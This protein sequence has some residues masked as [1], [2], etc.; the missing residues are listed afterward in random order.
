MGMRVALILHVFHQPLR[1]D[2]GAENVALRVGGNAFG[3][4]GGVDL[5]HGVGNERGDLAGLGVAD[6]DAALPADVAAGGD[7]RFGVGDVDHVVPDVDA[8]RPAELLPIG[9]VFAVL[10]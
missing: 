4:A 9:K 6:P 5:L 1:A 10:V 3:G 8:A 2:L 7:F